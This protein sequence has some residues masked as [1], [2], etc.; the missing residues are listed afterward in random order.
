VLGA[1]RNKADFCIKIIGNLTKCKH[2]L[3]MAAKVKTEF[4]AD[5]GREGR[6]YMLGGWCFRGEQA[7]PP[8]RVL[9]NRT[10]GN[11][12]RK[13][14]DRDVEETD[15]TMLKVARMA[16]IRSCIGKGTVQPNERRHRVVCD[17]GGCV[18]MRVGQA[19]H[20]GITWAMVL[21]IGQSLSA[22][23]RADVFHCDIRKSNVM[24]FGEDDFQLIDFD[25]AVSRDNNEFELHA[26][27]QL[28]SLGPRLCGEEAGTHVSW[29]ATDDWGM[30]VKMILDNQPHV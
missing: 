24:K 12:K 25:H 30:L 11:S 26:G 14:N 7:D 10:A 28:D 23:F 3:E 2:E 1:C 15:M 9:R 16:Q 4:N 17:T 29:N 19:V 21:G 6:F 8:R 18:I 20:G 13:R 27:G 22:C 5:V